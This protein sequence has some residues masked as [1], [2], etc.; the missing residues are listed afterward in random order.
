MLNDPNVQRLA[1]ARVA[2]LTK[3]V[4][5]PSHEPVLDVM[6]L[7]WVDGLEVGLQLTEQTRLSGLPG[8]LPEAVYQDLEHAELCS[9]YDEFPE[10]DDRDFQNFA[11]SRV[12]KLGR[13]IQPAGHPEVSGYTVEI[14]MDGVGTG[15]RIVKQD[16]PECQPSAV[17]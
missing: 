12:Q 10:L 16:Q 11:F 3:L 4:L 9:E 5:P 15:L 2:E 7:I 8:S 1:S 13:T 17:D 6:A 14:W